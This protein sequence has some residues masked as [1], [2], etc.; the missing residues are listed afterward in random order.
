MAEM[1]RCGATHVVVVSHGEP[2]MTLLRLEVPVPAEAGTDEVLYY[3]LKTRV[4]TESYQQ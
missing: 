3:R 2:K 4:Y 1:L